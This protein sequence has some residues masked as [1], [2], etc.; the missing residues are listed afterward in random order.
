MPFSCSTIKPQTF[1]CLTE[2]SVCHCNAVAGDLA[3][4]VVGHHKQQVAGFGNGYVI[5]AALINAFW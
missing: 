3:L 5:I 2:R 4:L 1:E